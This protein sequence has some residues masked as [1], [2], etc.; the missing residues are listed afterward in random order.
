[1]L[2]KRDLHEVPT[3]F[4]LSYH[5]D[6]YPYIRH[7]AATCDEFYFLTKHT[8]EAENNGEI[9]SRT[10]LDEYE[11]PIGT[12]NLFDIHNRSGF[13]ATWIGKPYFGKGYNKIAKQEF[14]DELFFTLDIETVFMKVRKTNLRSLKAVSKLDYVAH[15]NELY[16]EVY[17]AINKNE[18]VYDLFAITKEHY[19]TYVQFTQ[20]AV[21][22]T[23][24]VVS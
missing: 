20:I 2:K 8:M 1:M 9:I 13:L 22:E 19:V 18:E 14:L 12:I 17:Q 3:L 7:K 15:A 24:E 11:Q 6:V 23:A 10:I 4:E 5:P 16:P 21:Q